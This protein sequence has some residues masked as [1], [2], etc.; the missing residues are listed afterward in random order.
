MLAETAAVRKRDASEI[1]SVFRLTAL[2]AL[3][4][5]GQS[6]R[7]IAELFGENGTT[8]QRWVRRFEHG[9]LE[10]LREGERSGR[11]SALDAV[12]DH[13]KT[14]FFE[15]QPRRASGRLS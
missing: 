3:V 6:C 14:L 12:D 11:P 15:Q 2:S 8:V 5:A 4:T 10:A 7:Q 9:G 13:V 1:A